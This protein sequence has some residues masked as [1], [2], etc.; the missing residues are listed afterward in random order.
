MTLVLVI[1]F[2]SASLTKRNNSKNN[3]IGVNQPK[4]FT[5]QRKLSTKWKGYLLNGIRLFANDISDKELL[6]TT[7]EEL[8]QIN[9][10][11]R[12]SNTKMGETWTDTSEKGNLNGQ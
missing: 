7:Y 3:Q 11:E 9:E 12:Q 1:F 6:F 8:L 2:E 5:Q 4:K 10:Y